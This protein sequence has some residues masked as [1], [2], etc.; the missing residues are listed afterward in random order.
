MNVSMSVLREVCPFS[1]ARRWMGL[2]GFQGV[3]LTKV[4]GGGFPFEFC[5]CCCECQH[6]YKYE[7]ADSK[8]DDS[9]IADSLCIHSS[10]VTVS[11]LLHIMSTSMF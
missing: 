9:G 4:K 2:H 10:A 8:Y 6:Y 11:S 3:V 5:V 1:V 7:S